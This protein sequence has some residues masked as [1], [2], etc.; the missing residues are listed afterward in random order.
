M[1]ALTFVSAGISVP[2]ATRSAL[3]QDWT[4]SQSEHTAN[5][6]YV[7]LDAHSSAGQEPWRSTV[8]TLCFLAG[9]H[10]CAGKPR[11]QGLS[12]KSRRCSAAQKDLRVVVR[13]ACSTTSDTQ[14]CLSSR[15]AVVGALTSAIGSQ[16]LG[17]VVG[18]TA[19]AP[20]PAEPL[21]TA[22]DGLLGLGEV[23][24]LV[25]SIFGSGGVGGGFGD[26]AGGPITPDVLNL[27]RE[28]VPKVHDVLELSAGDGAWSKQLQTKVAPLLDWK[29]NIRAADI[30]VPRLTLTGGAFKMLGKD[31]PFGDISK[32]LGDFELKSPALLEGLSLYD[33]AGRDAEAS[34]A[35]NRGQ[36]ITSY[37]EDNPRSADLVVVRNAF[38]HCVNGQYTCAGY[39]IF[40]KPV[41]QF[42]KDMKMILRPGG[43]LVLTFPAAKGN[44][45]PNWLAQ[46]KKALEPE[47]LQRLTVVDPSLRDTRLNVSRGGDAYPY[48]IY[49]AAA[50]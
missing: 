39:S 6:G 12:A 47:E 29:V 31:N 34:R 42:A 21:V 33:G 46:F 36:S 13:Q 45:E 7:P 18:A 37:A 38:T 16:S 43:A 26:G 1:T 9:L 20:A 40:P 27:W 35:G 30:E 5:I 3:R 11:L 19:R 49:R 28:L 41:K 14:A 48:M 4:S 22:V 44:I 23:G 15:R 50:A 8:A 10:G 24:G 2:L 25:D 17:T 32:S